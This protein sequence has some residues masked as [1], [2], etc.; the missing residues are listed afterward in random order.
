MYALLFFYTYVTM[1][2]KYYTFESSIPPTDGRY[3]GM[4]SSS[5]FDY[6]EFMDFAKDYNQLDEISVASR[7]KIAKAAKRT[8]KIRTRKRK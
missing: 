7:R 1:E 3:V 2:D 5:W 4:S 6:D 8:A